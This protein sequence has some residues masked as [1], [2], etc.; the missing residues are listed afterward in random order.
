VP[1]T[2]SMNVT[3]P[4]QPVTMGDRRRIRL[5]WTGVCPATGRRRARAP[6]RRS[7]LAG[8]AVAVVLMVTVLLG[9]GCGGSASETPAPKETPKPG[10]SFVY[11]L[12]GDPVSIEP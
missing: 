4:E 10:G 12:L 8:G 3:P 2:L 11:P 1:L 9:V 5:P 7:S 6:W